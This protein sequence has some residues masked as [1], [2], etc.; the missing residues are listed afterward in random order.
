VFEIVAAFIFFGL[1]ILYIAAR[2]GGVFHKPPTEPPGETKSSEM[3]F[4]SKTNDTTFFD[5][6]S[7]DYA[8][9]RS[10]LRNTM[11]Y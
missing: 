1:I 11:G 4:D 9:A 10:S 8:K 7:E 2:F 3:L 5:G 6:E